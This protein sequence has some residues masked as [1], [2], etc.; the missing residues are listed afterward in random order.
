[1]YTVMRVGALGLDDD[2]CCDGEYEYMKT[3]KEAE[4]LVRKFKRIFGKDCD[5]LHPWKGSRFYV[6]E[7]S[8]D[9]IDLIRSKIS[10]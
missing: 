2:M 7:V 9:Y 4:S 1:M 10:L 5:D 3:K 6:Q 8:Q